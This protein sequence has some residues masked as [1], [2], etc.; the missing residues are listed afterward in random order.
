M[1]INLCQRKE[2]DLFLD[3]VF[4]N[5]QDD[6]YEMFEHLCETEGERAHD[7]ETEQDAYIEQFTQEH[8]IPLAS[9][10]TQIFLGL[11]HEDRDVIFHTHEAWHGEV[12]G[13]HLR[14]HI[15]ADL[16]AMPDSQRAL[17]DDDKEVVS[18]AMVSMVLGFM[19]IYM[20]LLS[21]PNARTVV[22]DVVDQYRE[23][24]CALLAPT[25]AVLSKIGCQTKGR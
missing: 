17:F 22:G 2:L 3:S 10:L 11:E 12:L 24:W 18:Y 5:M 6:I 4:M 25:E 20:D 7:D 15:G 21:D 16:I 23:H 9:A 19:D 14:K 13:R 8:F 1:H